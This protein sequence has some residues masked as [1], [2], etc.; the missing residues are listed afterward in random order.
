M[1][2]RLFPD[3]TLNVYLQAE[4]LRRTFPRWSIA[5]RARPGHRARIEAVSRDGDGLYCLISTD[6]AEIWRELR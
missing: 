1:T 4:A 5:V 2:G 6:P 3:A